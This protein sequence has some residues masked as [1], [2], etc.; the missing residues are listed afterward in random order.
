MNSVDVTEHKVAGTM[1]FIPIPVFDQ[2][3]EYVE[4]NLHIPICLTGMIY[5]EAQGP[6]NV[7]ATFH[8][9]A[10]IFQNVQYEFCS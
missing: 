4:L 5:N 1:K 10:F 2:G 3:E 8:L 9:F 6:F 7:W